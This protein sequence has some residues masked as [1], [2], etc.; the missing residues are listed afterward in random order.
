[1]KSK[2]YCILGGQYVWRYYGWKPSLLAAKRE[3]SKH[4]EYWD[5]WQGW[6][7][8]AIYREEDTVIINGDVMPNPNRNVYPVAKKVNGKWV[9]DQTV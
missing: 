5:N 9:T 2:G 6:H 8:P 3:A 7:T 4:E 1:M